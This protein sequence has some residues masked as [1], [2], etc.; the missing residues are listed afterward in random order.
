LA[1][2]VGALTT[3]KVNL[4]NTEATIAT[5]QSQHEVE[6]ARIEAENERL[7]DTNREEERRNRQST[8]H[9]YLN[10]VVGIYQLMGLEVSAKQ[11]N[12][13]RQDYR[14][15]HSGVVLFGPPCVR[16]AANEVSGAY[17]EVWVAM[18]RQREEYSEKTEPE[19]WRDATATLKEN[20][21]EKIVNLIDAMHADVTRGIT[22][23]PG[24]DS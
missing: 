3:Y 13:T 24:I 7:L 14:Y 4:R 19:R 20:F 11:V 18:A 21:S 8:Y 9:R 6:L 16:A 15:L 10:A 12:E 22:Q 23:D 17:N 1:A 5:A 2:S